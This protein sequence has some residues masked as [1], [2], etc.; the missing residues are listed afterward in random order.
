MAPGVLAAPILLRPQPGL[1]L[2]TT[3][4]P[5]T[6]LTLPVMLVLQVGC[7]RSAAERSPSAPTF[8]KLGFFSCTP[9]KRRWGFCAIGPQQCAAILVCTSLGSE[10]FASGRRQCSFHERLVAACSLALF[11]ADVQFHI[12]ALQSH[13]SAED[14]RQ[15]CGLRVGA[16]MRLASTMLRCGP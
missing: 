7:F 10:S 15:K 9:Q 14:P 1:P 13:V 12:N 2:R 4:P 11:P 3:H 16:H 8:R 5:L 6:L